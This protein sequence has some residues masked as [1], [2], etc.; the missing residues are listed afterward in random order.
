MVRSSSTV[1]KIANDPLDFSVDNLT[2]PLS[3]SPA[4]ISDLF[5]L[6]SSQ[7]MIEA[8]SLETDPLQTTPSDLISTSLGIDT[9]SNN[10]R[11]T[12]D[13]GDTKGTF[14]WIVSGQN[15]AGIETNTISS[16]PNYVLEGFSARTVASNPSTALGRGLFPVGST[17]SNPNNVVFENIAEGGNGPNGG[18]IY[19]Y[20]SFADGT[21]LVDSM[22]Y[23]NQFSV[24]DSNGIVSANG[25]HCYNLDKTIRD[26]NTSTAVPATAN[27][28]ED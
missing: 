6:T 20:R 28:K 15:L 1:V 23:D 4:G 12:V 13:D 26:A 25:D 5:N 22:D 7:Q 14:S 19:N 8:P 24:C 21:Q 17:I 11:I 2:S 10:Y 27:I 16:N 9:N 3:S 18:T